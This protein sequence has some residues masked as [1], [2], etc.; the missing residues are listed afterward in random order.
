[1]ILNIK[2]KFLKRFLL[3]RIVQSYII[4][5]HTIQSYCMIIQYYK[6]SRKFHMAILLSFTLIMILSTKGKILKR[7]I[8]QYDKRIEKLQ[9]TIL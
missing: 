6:R 3:D 2:G 9:M 4:S 5:Y 7:L 1:M 8:I